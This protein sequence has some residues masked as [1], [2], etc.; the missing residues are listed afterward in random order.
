MV[1]HRG[2]LATTNNLTTAMTNLL[3][4][5]LKGKKFVYRSK[6]GGETFGEIETCFVSNAITWDADTL[7][8]F[9]ANLDWIKTHS[10]KG[11]IKPEPIPVKNPY[12]AYNPKIRITST[13][14]IG[15]DFDEIFILN[16]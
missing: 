3:N 2:V 7:I 11:K 6:Y 1:T 12:S 4:E 15:Y 16:N 10:R 14:G 13:T 5:Q 9:Q 8:N